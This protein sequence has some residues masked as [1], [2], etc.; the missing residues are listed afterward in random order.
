MKVKEIEWGKEMPSSE[1]CR[2]NH[3][4]GK[5]DLFSF[6]ITW[7]SWKEY[8]NYD[9]EICYGNNTDYL[10]SCVS[11]EDAKK[12]AQIKFNELILSCIEVK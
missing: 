12:A 7:K 8:V 4:I 11:I 1:E 10:D 9:L 2:Y 6:W 5:T 3:I